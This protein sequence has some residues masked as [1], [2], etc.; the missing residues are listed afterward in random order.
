MARAA[1]PMFGGFRAATSTT[2]NRSDSSNLP[3]L[4]ETGKNTDF[5]TGRGEAFSCEGGWHRVGP[6]NSCSRF[7]RFII[8]F[9]RLCVFASLTRHTVHRH[10]GCALPLWPLVLPYSAAVT[11]AFVLIRSICS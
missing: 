8:A 9:L 11:W 3:N 1:A 6:C 2:R 10:Y 5:T 7:S 4:T